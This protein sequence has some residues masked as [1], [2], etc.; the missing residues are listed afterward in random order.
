MNTVGLLFISVESV[1][2]AWQPLPIAQD[3][4]ASEAASQSSPPGSLTRSEDGS[5]CPSSPAPQALNPSSSTPRPGS[6]QP[7]LN[8]DSTPILSPSMAQSSS[9]HNGLS[10]DE[11]DLEQDNDEMARHRQIERYQILEAAGLVRKPRVRH[12]APSSPTRPRGLTTGE[13][14]HSESISSTY[15]FPPKLDVP[16]A[17]CLGSSQEHVGE[18]KMQDALTRYLRM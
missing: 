9:T 8:S 3:T 1:V 4:V 11:S 15:P 7:P 18:E 10:E 13:S 17:D 14:R 12:P 16:G 5:R 2:A 6:R